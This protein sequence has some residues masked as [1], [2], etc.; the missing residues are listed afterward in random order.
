MKWIEASVLFNEVYWNTRVK[1]KLQYKLSMEDEAV[2][3]ME[4]AIELGEKMET[5]PFDFGRMIKLLEEWK[6]R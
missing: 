3:S 4:K 1:A 5:E 2:A 6:T